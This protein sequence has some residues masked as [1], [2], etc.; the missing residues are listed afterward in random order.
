MIRRVGIVL[1]ILAIAAGVAW[2]YVKTYRSPVAVVVAPDGA[3]HDGRAFAELPWKRL[4][5]LRPFEFTATDGQPFGTKQLHGQPFVVSFFFSTCPTICRDLNRQIARLANEFEG[6]DLQFVSLSVDP[7][8]DTPE[9]LATYAAE[10]E[11][12]PDQWHFLSGPIHRVRAIGQQQFNVVVDGE[13]HTGDL[14]LVDRWGRYR[15]R[16]GWDDPREMKRFSETVRE[17]LAE[18]S[19]PLEQT[20]RTRNVLASLEHATVSPPWLFDFQLTSAANEPFWS[21]D[22]TGRVQVVSFFFTRCPSICPR[23]NRY[24]AE[25][26]ADLAARNVALVSITTDPQHDDPA[27]LRQYARSLTAGDHWHFLTGDPTYIR[28]AGSEFLG[29]AADGEHHS[30]MLAVI[31]RWG[32]VRARVDWQAE[33]SREFLLQLVDRLNAEQQPEFTEQVE[34]NL[35]ADKEGLP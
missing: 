24:L 2:W 29:I 33:G 21:R 13:N 3:E 9:R 31:D 28:R 14:F 23:Q 22:L 11:A 16:F 5:Q 32:Q 30:S 17:V 7:D 4:P 10:F 20:V 19:P 26:Q 1:W 6:T 12:D 18:S 25:L 34:S 8:K 35:P 15:D 27:V